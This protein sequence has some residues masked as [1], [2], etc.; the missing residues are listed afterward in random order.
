MR[1]ALVHDYLIERGGA[2]QVLEAFLEIW[3]KAPIYTL[4][5]D[6]KLTHG[7]F[8]GRRIYTS[9]LQKLPFSRSRHRFFLC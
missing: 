1:I 4:L 2:E 9:F 7:R 6:E 5:Y 3:P 8:K